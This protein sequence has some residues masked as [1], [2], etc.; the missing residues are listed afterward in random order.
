MVL[1]RVQGI[2]KPYKI[3][4]H[5]TLIRG[6]NHEN[7]RFFGSPGKDYR[8]CSHGALQGC[9]SSGFRVVSLGFRGSGFRDD[10][11]YKGFRVEGR[12]FRVEGLPWNSA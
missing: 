9:D 12:G 4:C 6:S 10:C 3:V 7:H 11:N 1:V 2:P 8:V 5:E